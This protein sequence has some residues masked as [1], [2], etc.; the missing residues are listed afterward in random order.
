MNR[1]IIG[2]FVQNQYL[3]IGE[4]HTGKVVA[5]LLK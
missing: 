5:K 3:G 4:L 1:N 2:T